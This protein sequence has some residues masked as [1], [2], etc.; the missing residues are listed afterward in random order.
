MK[1]AIANEHYNYFQHHQFIEFED[2][3]SQVQLDKLKRLLDETCAK[4]LAVTPDKL[5]GKD[6]ETLFDAGRDLWRD[7]D[8][9]RKLI[10]HKSGAEVAANLTG[11]KPLRAG[12][13]QCIFSPTPLGLRSAR[14]PAFAQIFS[15]PQ[16]ITNFSSIDGLCCLAIICLEDQKEENVEGSTPHPIPK[17]AGSATYV[18]PSFPLD[19]PSLISASQRL[20]LMAYAQG[21]A[22]YILQEKDPQTY[23][24]KRQGYLP[25]S[26]LNDR[27]NPVLVR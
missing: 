19:F 21:N 4:R 12:F 8:E 27:L 16:P 23:Y 11:L 25:N 5:K 6:A 22:Q 14:N 1:L 10:W 17:K 2:Y 3:L 26:Q 7:N 15:S 20:L 9:L 24:L 13:T 18:N